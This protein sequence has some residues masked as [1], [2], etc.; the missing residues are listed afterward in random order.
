ML[1]E[2]VISST[3]LG[4][5]QSVFLIVLTYDFEQAKDIQSFNFYFVA[6]VFLLQLSTQAK[7]ICSL[8]YINTNLRS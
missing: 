8:T 1:I 3:C 4:L 5:V 6:Y 2:A 7:H